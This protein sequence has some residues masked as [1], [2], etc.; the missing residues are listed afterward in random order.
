MSVGDASAK[1]KSVSSGQQPQHDQLALAAAI[2]ESSEDAILSKSLDGRI[3]SWNNAAVRLYG[4]QPEQIIGQPITVLVPP[5][6]HEEEQ[7]ILE[8]ISQGAQIEHYETARLTREGQR[9]EVSLTVSPIRDAGGR[10]VAASSISRDV[11][12][13][14]RAHR[15]RAQLAAIVESSDDAIVGKN[16]DGIIQS[17]NA[18]AT[19]IFGYTAEEI[20][21]HPITTIIPPELR[22]EERHI[23]DHIRRGERLDH[24]D[25]VR[26][27]KD[28]RRIPISLTISPILDEWGMVTGA[29]KVA[30]D[31]SERKLA[32]RL[33]RENQALLAGTAT[34][35]AKLTE[36]SSRL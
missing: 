16:L 28:G 14:R 15:T 35:L 4:Y 19:R 20:I 36:W 11:T 32:E 25:T 21:G 3:L 1:L 22:D 31:I 29:S 30:R 10:V 33:Q 27:T 34:A 5:E 9:L 7:R 26:V 2:I 23:L 6:L 12:E 8:Q 17:W 13:Q 24:F 18:G